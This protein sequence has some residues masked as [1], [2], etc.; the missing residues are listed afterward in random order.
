[1]ADPPALL[2]VHERSPLARAAA[3]Q[4][5]RQ[6]TRWNRTE[7]CTLQKL[8]GSRLHLPFTPTRDVKPEV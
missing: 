4:Q 6:P 1:M 5:L 2:E 8:Q 7:R 3:G